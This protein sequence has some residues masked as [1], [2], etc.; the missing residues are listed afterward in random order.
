MIESP[1]RDQ[2]I[3][4]RERSGVSQS[5]MAKAMGIPQPT[6]QALVYGITRIKPIH[7]EM[8]KLALIKIAIAKGDGSILTPELRDFIQSA[9]QL[10]A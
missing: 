3:A 8:A 10:I 7:Y 5:E 1:E 4:L 2:M 9:Y 6:Y